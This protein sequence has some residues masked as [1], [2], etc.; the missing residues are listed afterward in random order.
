[1]KSAGISAFEV[2]FNRLLPGDKKGAFHSSDLWYIFG[3][4]KNSWRPFTKEDYDLS[5][6]MIDYYTSFAKTGKPEE[7]A[8]EGPT[9]FDV[10]E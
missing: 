5:A 8:E 10:Q 6:R 7:A 4:L 9:V 1:M 2:R 3:T